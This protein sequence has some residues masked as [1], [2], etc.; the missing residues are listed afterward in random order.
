[1]KVIRELI[2]YFS[3]TATL[4]DED[5]RQL[6]LAGWTSLAD[7]G[8]GV[9][10]NS[11]GSIIRP[12]SAEDED[13]DDL[14]EDEDAPEFEPP[15]PHTHGG[16][17]RRPKLRTA[18]APELAAWLAARLPD[19]RP[20]LA[21]LKALSPESEEGHAP[22]ALRHLNPADSHHA[23]RAALDA[24]R[25]EWSAL[26]IALLMEDYRE[27]FAQPHARRGPA[28][29]AFRALLA[30][31]HES[32]VTGYRWLLRYPAI[33]ETAL[34]SHV[35]G[36]LLRGMQHWLEHDPESLAVWIGR[37][38]SAAGLLTLTLAEHAT[39]RSVELELPNRPLPPA[40]ARAFAVN[41][42]Y[43]MNPRGVAERLS[44]GHFPAGKLFTAE[45]YA[46]LEIFYPVSW[47]LGLASS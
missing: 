26:W 41:A 6:R 19:W 18:K 24:K 14:P 21:P 47:N 16:G 11:D 28:T 30:A 10:F 46:E 13:G 29:Q 1:M 12:I 43:T 17:A 4:T 8:P 45:T 5:L 42:V 34:Y 15:A 37:G 27:W 25:L 3:E 40:G 2:H 33:A 7:E 23:L 36:A 9:H 20:R 39:G 35:R 31:I 44:E 22:H 32:E 38:K